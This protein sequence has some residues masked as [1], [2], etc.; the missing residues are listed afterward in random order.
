MSP[1]LQFQVEGVEKPER[2]PEIRPVQAGKNSDRVGS[3]EDPSDT[4]LFSRS[5]LVRESECL[6]IFGIIN[7]N[8]KQYEKL[9]NA[10]IF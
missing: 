1:K 10:K 9:Q 8:K 2:K 6:I 7:L 5:K 3:S 4:I